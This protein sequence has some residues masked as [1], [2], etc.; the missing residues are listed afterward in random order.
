ME[1]YEHIM[2]AGGGNF[3]DMPQQQV[4]VP[5][6]HVEVV[7]PPPDHTYLWMS[8][9]IVP[10]IVAAIGLWIAHRRRERS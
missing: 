3:D 6:V 2:V 5:Q 1:Q 7:Q 4:A 10:I 9:V 8:G